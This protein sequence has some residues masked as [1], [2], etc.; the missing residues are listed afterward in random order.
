MYNKKFLKDLAKIPSNERRSIEKFVFK[1]FPQVD[2]F[3]SVNKIKKLKGNKDCFKARFG[4]YR[5][6]IR[7]N[8]DEVVFERVLHRKEIHRF[9]P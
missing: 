2:L 1:E 8:D 5:I 6:G 7:V 4:D 9:F 3:S